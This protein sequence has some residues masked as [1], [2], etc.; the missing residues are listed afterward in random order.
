MSWL[1][2]WWE[3]RGIDAPPPSSPP[4]AWPVDPALPSSWW[5][6]T[7]RRWREVRGYRLRLEF[8]DACR[9]A[10]TWP[11][12][13]VIELGRELVDVTRDF[14]ATHGNPLELLQDDRARLARHYR[15]AARVAF[16]SAPPR[17]TYCRS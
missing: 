13:S 8:E 9:R 5:G 14:A 17:A 15:R 6:R 16:H 10:A 12:A 11:T 7:L 3:M 2:Q 1:R 4:T